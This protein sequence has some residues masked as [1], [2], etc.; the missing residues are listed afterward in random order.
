M[1]PEFYFYTATTTFQP[2][3]PE[4]NLSNYFEA[5]QYDEDATY[6]DLTDA[7]ETEEEWYDSR[8]IIPRLFL[9]SPGKYSFKKDN[10]MF[11]YRGFQV[12]LD[13]Y[14]GIMY[15][16]NEE[17]GWFANSSFLVEA[18]AE[19]GIIKDFIDGW[20]FSQPHPEQ[21]KIPGLALV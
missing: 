14:E 18:D 17:F 13:W 9:V 21:L 2:V 11:E 16:A 15:I 3:D 6:F 19:I 5:W 10:E 7:D 20:Y 12:Y 1:Y 4:F 8:Y